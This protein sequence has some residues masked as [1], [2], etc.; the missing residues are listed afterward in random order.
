T[1]NAP[2]GHRD[3]NQGGTYRSSSASD[4]EYDPDHNFK[5]NSWSYADPR[6]AKPSYHGRAAKGTP[7]RDPR[8]HPSPSAICCSIVTWRSGYVWRT[9]RIC[10]SAPSRPLD[11]PVLSWES[12]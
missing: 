3:W 11:R 1:S 7:C 8:G 12:M 6:F 10:L 9:P 2:K 4:L 5:L